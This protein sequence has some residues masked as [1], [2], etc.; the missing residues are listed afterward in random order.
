MPS[1][2]THKTYDHRLCELVHLTG[3][4]TVATKLGVPRSTAAGWLRSA[5]RTVVTAD[6]LS[7]PEMELQAEVV[8]LKSPI[9]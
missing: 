7:K 2:H 1:P 8:R 9:R 5:R 3:D 4:L 6:V